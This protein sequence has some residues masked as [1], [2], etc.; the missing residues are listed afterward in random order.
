[1]VIK[2]TRF[3]N[4]ILNDDDGRL[5]LNGQSFGDE[6]SADG[7]ANLFIF[8]HDGIYI[9]HLGMRPVFQN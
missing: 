9:N 3:Q 4:Q 5:I 1:M 8:Y 6:V 7:I 2:F